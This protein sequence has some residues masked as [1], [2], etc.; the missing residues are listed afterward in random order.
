MEASQ[1]SLDF[2]GTT[3][4]EDITVATVVIT[5]CARLQANRPSTGL[6][7][8]FTRQAGIGLAKTRVLDIKHKGG[9]WS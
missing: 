1:G 8:Q 6:L 3:G 7:K 5:G 2:N 4:E 9:Y